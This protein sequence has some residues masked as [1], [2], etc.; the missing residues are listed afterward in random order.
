MKKQIADLIRKL[1]GHEGEMK[2]LR[3]TLK[4]K[5]SQMTSSLGTGVNAEN[6]KLKLQSSERERGIHEGAP[7][8]RWTFESF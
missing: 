6:A 8:S 5:D 4:D 3:S 2:W 7:G 1:H